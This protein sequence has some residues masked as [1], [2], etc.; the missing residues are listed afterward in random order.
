M[1]ANTPLFGCLFI[2]F[3]LRFFLGG[4]R[5]IG[6]RVVGISGTVGRLLPVFWVLGFGVGGDGIDGLFLAEGGGAACD[7]RNRECPGSV[8]GAGAGV[9]SHARPHWSRRF[10][11][12]VM[13]AGPYDLWASLRSQLSLQWPLHAQLRQTGSPL[14]HSGM[15]GSPAPV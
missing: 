5:L 13:R 8:V 4:G 3:R 14:E 6:L 1:G 7:V 10:L 12:F 11:I 2:M 9:R 15:G